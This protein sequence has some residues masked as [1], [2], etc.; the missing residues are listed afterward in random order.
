[1]TAPEVELDYADRPDASLGVELACGSQRV[2]WTI[3]GY[4]DDLEKAVAERLRETSADGP[5]EHA[6]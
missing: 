4:L 6:A 1:M 5:R 3:A 2:A